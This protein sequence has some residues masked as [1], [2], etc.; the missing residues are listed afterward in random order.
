MCGF[1]QLILAAA[2]IASVAA[3]A[4]G[5]VRVGDPAPNFRL[6]DIYDRW[7]QLSEYRGSVVLLDLVEYGC[8]RCVTAAPA[9]EL[10]WQEYGTTGHFQVLGL[11]TYDGSITV[12]QQFIET[13]GVTFPVLR[14]AG[15]LQAA[16]TPPCDYSYGLEYDNFVVVD[17]QGIVRYTSDN[18]PY[19]ALYGRYDS[20]AIRA[21]IEASLPTAV[22]GRSWSVVKRL[23]Q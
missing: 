13:T 17:M 10:L 6:M 14:D 11:E 8:N 16:C 22:E 3:R 5:A 2:L 4:A 1:R 23:F 7:Y 12:V 15:Y 19:G 21:A 20:R 18:R 9:V